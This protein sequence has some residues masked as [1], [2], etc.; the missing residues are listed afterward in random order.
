MTMS[1]P[2]LERSDPRSLIRYGFACLAVT[3]VLLWTLYLVRSTL[4]V[5]Y[6][7]ALFATGLA[8]L[9]RIIERR[10]LLPAGQGRLPRTAGPRHQHRP[11]CVHGRRSRRA[12]SVGGLLLLRWRS[13]LG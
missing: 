1:P 12:V 9:V 4:L 6:V 10:R 8:P 11:A 13:G 5:L 7:S 2:S 3:I